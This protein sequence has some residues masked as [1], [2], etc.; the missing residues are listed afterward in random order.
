[1]NSMIRNKKIRFLLSA[2][3]LLAGF[4]GFKY[5]KVKPAENQLLT[6]ENNDVS[7]I[8]HSEMTAQENCP[9]LFS[10]SA[11]EYLAS[12]ASDQ[13]DDQNC[14]ISGCGGSL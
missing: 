4:F 12:A 3:A 5:D 9:A 8:R 7:G 13:N 1:M 2:A 10:K 14:F 11:D 6:P